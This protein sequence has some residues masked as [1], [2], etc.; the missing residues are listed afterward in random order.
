MSHIQLKSEFQ[1]GFSAHLHFLLRAGAEHLD[2]VTLD[3]LFDTAVGC[4]AQFLS[5]AVASAGSVGSVG[6]GWA[7]LD[8]YL[9]E[10]KTFKSHYCQ[11]TL[12]RCNNN[13][14]IV[15]Q[16]VN[17][18]HI[19][20]SFYILMQSEPTVLHWICS[21]CVM[22]EDAACGALF[23]DRWQVFTCMCLAHIC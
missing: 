4:V 22:L 16:S 1:W 20:Y 15:T 17:K 13:K 2:S 5:L 6:S 14:L 7:C 21:V 11:W 18:A 10:L 12:C 19:S 8:R 23:C 9:S 3:E